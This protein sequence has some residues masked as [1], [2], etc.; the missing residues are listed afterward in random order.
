MLSGGTEAFPGSSCFVCLPTV[1]CSLIPTPP[2]KKRDKEEDEGVPS[3]SEE[4]KRVL[5]MKA[6]E[7]KG[8]GRVGGNPRK[9]PLQSGPDRL[10][11]T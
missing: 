9:L 3:E 10:Q 4:E 1:P 7:L 11:S 6:R 5:D 2:S 8:T